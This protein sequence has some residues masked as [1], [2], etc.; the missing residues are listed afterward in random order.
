LAA[1]FPVK[2]SRRQTLQVAGRRS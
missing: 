2:R 1:A